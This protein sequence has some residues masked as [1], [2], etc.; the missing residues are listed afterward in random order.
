MPITIAVRYRTYEVLLREGGL[1]LG[2][3]RVPD[4]A[5]RAQSGK[6]PLELSRS[7]VQR[8]LV[9]FERDEHGQRQCRLEEARI[10]LA[11]CP[12]C[13]RRIRVL[14]CD[15]LPRKRYALELIEHEVAAHAGGA[16]S[17]RQVAWSVLGE[18]TPAHTT[19]FA[20]TEGLGAHVLGRAS[21]AA[22]GA[23]P[24]S[25]LLAETVARMPAA[26][27]AARAQVPVDPRRYRSEA[28]HERLGALARLV[29][30]AG[31]VTGRRAPDSFSDWRCLAL[32]WSLAA[33]LSFRTGLS[34]TG[35]EH[36][37]QKSGGGSRPACPTP[38][39]RGPTR[40]RSPPRA[41]S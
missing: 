2:V 11:R 24:F 9:L 28:R 36:L 5:C 3:Q 18:P 22:L 13:K 6:R 14:P 27:S 15:V 4:G 12:T 35:I 41:S 33:P 29:L 10:A 40:A 38:P 17:L 31:L 21:G 34:C 16:P 37:D 1:S 23:E 32:S 25:R 30:V 39:A 8:K 20:W 26:E 19:L 7:T